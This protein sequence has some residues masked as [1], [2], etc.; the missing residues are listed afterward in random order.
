MVAIEE[1]SGPKSSPIVEL[2]QDLSKLNLNGCSVSQDSSAS[3]PPPDSSE[4]DIYKV[5]GRSRFEVVEEYFGDGG[6]GGSGKRSQHHP[7]SFIDV[8]GLE[9]QKQLLKELVLHPLRSLTKTGSRLH[10]MYFVCHEVVSLHH[11]G[12]LFP[13]GIILYG[14]SGVGKSLLAQALAGESPSHS[15]HLS[16]A[17]LLTQESDS[18][19]RKAFSE[20]R[21]K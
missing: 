7:L 11:S 6:S 12:V 4:F 13:H 9:K 21:E 1:N 5:T 20:A 17:Q 8:G 2:R 19:L 18:V 10:Y 15:V 3:S 16:A 14:P